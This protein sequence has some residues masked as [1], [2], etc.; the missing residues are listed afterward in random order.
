MS[1][2]PVQD[3]ALVPGSDEVLPPGPHEVLPPSA[4]EV[5]PPGAHQVLP[6]GSDEVLPGPLEVPAVVPGAR[7]VCAFGSSFRSGIGPV[8]MLRWHPLPSVRLASLSQAPQR[9]LVSEGVAV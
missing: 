8:L 2:G 6:P 1:A 9:P 7:E 4:H 3:H 5:L